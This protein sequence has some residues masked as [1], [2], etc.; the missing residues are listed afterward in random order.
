MAITL[1]RIPK[2][3]GPSVTKTLAEWGLAPGSMRSAAWVVGQLTLTARGESPAL[4]DPIFEYLDTIKLCEDG[5][6]IWWGPVLR[7]PATV[8]PEQQCGYTIGDPTW[9]LQW[10]EFKVPTYPEPEDIGLML[11]YTWLQWALTKC[12]AE[13]PVAFEAGDIAA[14]TTP[15]PDLRSSVYCLELIQRVARLHPLSVQWWDLSGALPTF[16]CCQRSGLAPVSVARSRCQEPIVIE[17]L[18]DKLLTGVR[19]A[20]VFTNAYGTRS[21]AVDQAGPGPYTGANSLR[22]SLKVGTDAAADSSANYSAAYAATNYRIAAALYAPFAAAPWAGTLVIKGT[23]DHPLPVIRPGQAL[24]LTG[25]RA[26]WA[27]MGAQ[28]QLVSRTVGERCEILT[29]ELGCGEHLGPTDLL[30]IARLGSTSAGAAAGN[31]SPYTPPTPPP[32]ND[33]GTPGTYEDLM[34]TLLS[35]LP[36][37]ELLTSDMSLACTLQ[38]FTENEGHA[39]TPPR[40]FLGIALSGTWEAHIA[41]YGF[42]WVPY[43]GYERMV[44]TGTSTVHPLTGAVTEG[45]N[46]EHHHYVGEEGQPTNTPQIEIVM[47]G[48]WDYPAVLFDVSATSRKVRVQQR[49]TWALSWHIENSSFSL[50][51]DTSGHGLETRINENFESAEI[52]RRSAAAE[53]SAYSTSDKTGLYTARTART[54]TRRRLRYKTEVQ[55]DIPGYYHLVNGVQ[56]WVPPVLRA[57]GTPWGFYRVTVLTFRRGIGATTWPS[58]PTASAE[59]VL[60]CDVAGVLPAIPE[61]EVDCPKGYEVRVQLGDLVQL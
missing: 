20:Y 49:D 22:C 52:E 47:P 32:S 10:V 12:A 61:T 26:A 34:S 4:S 48:G 60:Q 36:A 33:P 41:G 23:P 8:Q 29:V 18:H 43:D 3:G 56:T 15:C 51:Y 54:F 57:K 7:T 38:G 37:I 50:H 44:W 58:E 16:R 14:F 55:A 9:Y 2:A 1:E 40:Y 13:M 46:F 31:P 24:N 35:A 45:G 11:G 17:P 6:C 25:G 30:A 19:I 42:G 21:E 53:W 5:V 39:S 27:T 59:Y 28:V